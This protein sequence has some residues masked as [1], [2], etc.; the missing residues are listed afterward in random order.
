M[1]V[2]INQNRPIAFFD[3]DGV[4]VRP[5]VIRHFPQHLVERTPPMFHPQALADMENAYESYQ[6]RRFTYREFAELW[7]KTYAI[8]ITGQH[9]SQIAKLAEQFWAENWNLVYPY[10]EELTSVLK[11]YC[12]LV[13]VSGSTYDSLKPF[14][15]RLGFDALMASEVQVDSRGIFVPDRVKNRAIDEEKRKVVQNFRI[16]LAD[17]EIWDK[18]FGF[19]DNAEHDFPL[20]EF[21]G[22]PYL[23]ADFSTYEEKKKARTAFF[24]L[25][26]ALPSVQLFR[27]P[28]DSKMIVEFVR[29]RLDA[30]GLS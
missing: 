13:A 6:A 21:V 15:D 23:L 17:P 8:G 25:R 19:G 9:S 27:Q 22:S 20:L 10:T 29:S 24:K 26:Q 18:S 3:V 7:V 28:D 30:I 2:S 11:P 12:T 5:Y 14:C 4:L 16:A 1:A